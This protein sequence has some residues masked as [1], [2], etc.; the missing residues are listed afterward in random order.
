[1]ILNGYKSGFV[2]VLG[3]EFVGIVVEEGANQGKRVVGSINIAHCG[4]GDDPCCEFCEV[5][6]GGN[7][8]LQRQVVG[9]LH[10]QGAFAEYLV[11]PF[12][13]LHVVPDSLP[14][15]VAVFTEPLAAA[16]RAAEQ[17]RIHVQSHPQA[18]SRKKVAV[19]GDGKLGSLVCQ[20][21]RCEFPTSNLEL[22]V[23]G[24]H[25][26]K[27]GDI[28]QLTW[29]YFW[30]ESALPSFS[31][32][33]DVVVECTGSADGANRAV[34]AVKSMGLVVL[35]STCSFVAGEATGLTTSSVN[36]VVVRE[37]VVCGSRCGPFDRALRALE[38]GEVKVNGLVEAVLPLGELALALAAKRG[39]KKVLMQVGL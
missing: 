35:K 37:L 31:Q 34:G 32:Y 25:A 30:N 13:N 22:H 11:M 6:P 28:C 26:S 10:H 8:C 16:F 18:N 3:H 21:L 17:V 36:D 38:L 23:F 15:Q 20:A 29:C 9:I 24:R 14:S 19:L 27:M 7:H 5:S 39:S 33:F 12:A 2:G 4:R 1:M